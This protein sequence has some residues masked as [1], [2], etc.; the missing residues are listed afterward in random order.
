[1]N[2]HDF[3]DAS[4]GKWFSKRNYRYAN[5]KEQSVITEFTVELQKDEPGNCTIQ[6]KSSIGTEGTMHIGFMQDGSIVRDRGYFTQSATKGSWN[7]D[8][9]TLCMTTSYDGVTYRETITI[10][11]D[12]RI[13]QTVGTKDS[14]G[15]FVLSGQY[16][17]QREPFNKV[18]EQ[19]RMPPAPVASLET[20]GQQAKFAT[21]KMEVD[22]QTDTDQLKAMVLSLAKLDIVHRA[23]I[24]KL[25][26]AF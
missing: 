26:K 14:D 3:L 24:A 18:S 10:A 19:R 16:V 9:N 6:W 20:L 13:R 4:S 21:I 15:A 17:E 11:G 7:M 8:G 12:K 22:S 5:G 2:I 23:T 1:M 25:V